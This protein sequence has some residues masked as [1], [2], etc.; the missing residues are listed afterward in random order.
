[1]KDVELRFTGSVPA[2][3]DQLMV[4]LIFQPYAD[5][6][7]RRAAAMKPRR[8]LE[9][10]AGTGVVTEAISKLLP[11]A[12]IIATDLNEPMLEVAG[13]R[14]RSDKVC[15]ITANAQEIPFDAE[16]FDLVVCQ[17]GAMFFPDK[18]LAHREARRVLRKGGHYLL[19]IW[20]RID[21]NPL[22]DATQRV[23]ID[24]FPE[25]PPLFL[26]EG[27]FGY[28]DPERIERDLREAGFGTVEID[29]VQLTSRSASASDAASA[30]CYGTPMSVELQDR[31]Q[32]S[33]DRAFEEVKRALGEFEGANGLEAPM[34]AH[35]V[36]ATK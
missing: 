23:L 16:G 32:G 35:I 22:S 13:Q 11:D 27:P 3:Y 7:A 15:F 17:F 36:T 31:E 4:P 30:L 34:S 6:L 21:R 10:A 8:I 1:M 33:L 19:A 20:D 14:I 12:Q 29:T 5:E 26:C 2:N 9:T 18:V 25:N 24:L 28:S